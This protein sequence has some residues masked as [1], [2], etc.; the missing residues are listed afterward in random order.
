MVSDQIKKGVDRAPHRSLLYALGL[1][2]EEMARP[3][4]AVVSAKSDIIPGHIHLDKIAEAVKAGV[5]AA[6]GTPVVVPAIGVCDGIV[7]GHKGMH[8]SLASR[9]LIADSV[10]TLLTAHCFDGAVLIPNCD[11][12]VPG[13]LMV[14][15]LLAMFAMLLTGFYTPA[16]VMASGFGSSVALLCM[17]GMLLIY[18]FRNTKGDEVLIRYLISRPF[19]SGHPIRF[20]LVFNL[21]IAL[22]SIFMDVGGMLL[23][24]AFVNAIADVVGYEEDTHWKRY[25][26][27]SV[28]ILS[29]CAT[30]VLPSKGGSLLTLGSFSGA[31]TEAGYTLD[32]ACFILTNLLT[33]VLLAVA[34]ALL[35]KPLFR[36]D[37]TRMQE[38]DVAQLVKDGESVRLN[39]RQVWSGVIMVIGFAFPVIQMCFPAESAV[40]AW[41]NGVGQ[42][43]FMALLVAAL[44]L[45]CIDGQPICKAADAFSKGVLWDVYIGIA[46]VVLL[47][48]AMSNADCGIGSWISLL[49]GNVFNGM[50]FP[51]MLLVVVALSGA[52]TQV[53]SNGATMVIVSSVIAQF[54]V[55]YAAA[56]VNVAVF[57]ALIAQVCQMGCLT[58]AASGFAAML[59]A[60]PCM[61]KKPNWVFKSG[62]L[63]M[64]LYLII[65]IP[66]GVLLA[67]V[68]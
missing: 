45:I 30:N 39:K 43:F 9:E 22:L 58:P 57:P 53:F 15:S 37:L 5:Y 65:A 13:M 4:I 35:A 61:Q 52:V 33:V 11:K 48:G 24:F 34:L 3:L 17:F 36:V 19:L 62:T 8:Y 29:Q 66:V 31:L 14:P 55:S 56:G 7:M 18:A 60:L 59:L 12:I 40:Y 21:A 20:L 54:A 38:L 28:L 46:A 41:M 63:M 47:S 10:E 42:I 27:T 32:T 23:G 49:L 16:A 26:M 1:T 25:M 64:L 50:S 51:V 2:D 67:C 6:G 44:E 68:L